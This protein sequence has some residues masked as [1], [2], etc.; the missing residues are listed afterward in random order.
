MLSHKRRSTF[1]FPDFPESIRNDKNPPSFKKQTSFKSLFWL[2]TFDESAWCCYFSRLKRHSY[3]ETQFVFELHTEGGLREASMW[4]TVTN[5]TQT[6]HKQGQMLL[7]GVGFRFRNAAAPVSFA[8]SPRG[9]QEHQRRSASVWHQVQMTL[10]GEQRGDLFFWF[11]L[12][13][14]ML[15]TKSGVWDEA[16]VVCSVRKGDY[17]FLSYTLLSSSFFDSRASQQR[18]EE[19]MENN[20]KLCWLIWF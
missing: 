3:K 9:V 19:K 6:H 18:R 13:F 20:H 2:L 1:R 16:G 12:C 17:T 10:T 11:Y 4:F 15:K 14:L 7:S 5:Q 8:Q